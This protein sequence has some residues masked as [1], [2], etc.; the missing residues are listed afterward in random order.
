M[1]Q[2]RAKLDKSRLKNLTQK[3]KREIRKHKNEPV[4]KYLEDLKNYKST[5][6]SLWKASTKQLLNNWKNSH[7][8]RNI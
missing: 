8:K 1:Q 3:P 5:D 6:Y 7:N 4:K 2:T